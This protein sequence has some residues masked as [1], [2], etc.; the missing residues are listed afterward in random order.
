MAIGC[1]ERFAIEAFQ[2]DLGWSSFEARKARSN[3][4]YK[5]RLRLVDNEWW[6][7]RLFRYASLT[8][9][10]TQ[11]CTHLGSLKRKFGF[12]A[13]PVIEDK[14]Y[15]WAHAV[16][17]VCEEER[18]LWRRAMEDKSTLLTYRTHKTDI[19]MEPFYD[20]SGGNAL[21]FEAWQ[22]PCVRWHTVAGSTHL[23]TWPGPY[24][25][26]VAPKRRLQNT[27]SSAAL[28]CARVT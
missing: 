28:T 14:M 5:G 7:R 25:K 17:T 21:I 19:G 15:K 12:F 2:G 4:T 9:R 6:P 20:N 11:W 8:G 1:H 13:N 18:E 22:E 10:Q 23:R 26:Y 27:S 24:A 16:K 3:A